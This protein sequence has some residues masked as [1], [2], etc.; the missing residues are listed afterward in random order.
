[1]TTNHDD[2][3]RIREEIAESNGVRTWDALTYHV[4]RVRGEL[5]C[6]AYRTGPNQWAARDP[7]G[8]DLPGVYPTAAQALG[9]AGDW[10]ERDETAY[11]VPSQPLRISYPASSDVPSTEPARLGVT[12]PIRAWE[13]VVVAALAGLVGFLYGVML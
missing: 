7:F 10:P 8:K 5:G 1:M 9:S 2:E 13:L 11:P 3:H 6:L 12:Q 4:P